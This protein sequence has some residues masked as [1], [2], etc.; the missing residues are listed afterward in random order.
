MIKPVEVVFRN[1]V[2]EPLES[3]SL[4]EGMRM[5]VLLLVPDNGSDAAFPTADEA[6]RLRDLGYGAF[7]DIPEEEW[8]KITESWKRG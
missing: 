7:A 1:G 3:I 8:E 5:R 4:Q 6:Q 2:F